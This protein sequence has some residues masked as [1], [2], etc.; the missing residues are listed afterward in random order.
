MHKLTNEEFVRRFEQKN[1]DHSA[2]KIIDKYKNSR[3]A[4]RVKHIKCGHV[5]YVIPRDFMRGLN[6]CPKC[7]QKNISKIYRRPK[8]TV[9]NIA[10]K[11]LGKEYSIL[12]CNFLDT[13]DKP[14]YYLT[15]KHLTCGKVYTTRQDHITS[16]KR[17]CSCTR[18]TKSVGEDLLAKYF[19]SNSIKFIHPKLFDGLLDK[20]KLHYDFYLPDLNVLVEYQGMQ[21]YYKNHQ[22]TSSGRNSSDVWDLQIKHDNMKRQYANSNGYILIEV[23]YIFD[24]YEKVSKYTSKQL[25]LKCKK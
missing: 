24:T 12:S 15:I 16:D 4:I 21:H 7:H 13:G 25:S 20:Q 18:K 1:Q 8:A 2:Y 14:S 10:K 5:Y 19:I 17:K 9:I 23:P 22:I 6:R 11:V 3:T